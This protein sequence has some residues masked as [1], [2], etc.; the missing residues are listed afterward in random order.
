MKELSLFSGAGGGVYGSKLLGWKTI[1]YVEF[2]YYPQQIL[3]KRIDDGIFDKAPIFTDVREFVQ[4]GAARQY[5]G[6][7]DVVSGGFP[8][9][10]FSVAGKRK[11]SDD[12]RDMWPATMEVIRAVKPPIV[13]LENVPGLLSAT[14]DDGTGRLVHYFGTILRDLAESGYDVKWCV[15]GADDVGG[16]HHRKRVWILA[17]NTKTVKSNGAKFKA[18]KCKK[19]S[20]IQSGNSHSELLHSN[21]WSERIQGRISQPL[22]RQLSL[23]RG[24]IIRSIE[25]LQ[26]RTDIPKPVVWGN[27]DGMAHRRNRTRAIGNGQVSLCMAAAY[28]IL[29]QEFAK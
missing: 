9:Q 26:R 17:S 20:S 1:G 27:D 11:A 8:C 2:S 29:S 5:R 28:E 24:E 22:F 7:V 16:I 4:S 12:S 15:L 13:Y 18:R 6:F 25:D 21:S 19:P 3:R 14:V 10:P 23:Q